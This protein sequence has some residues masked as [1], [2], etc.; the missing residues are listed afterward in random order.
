MGDAA[1]FVAEGALP[2]RAGLSAWSDLLA[3]ARTRRA[4]WIESPARQRED[5]ALAARRATLQATASICKLNPS[6]YRFATHSGKFMTKSRVHC[7]LDRALVVLVIIA[8]AIGCA[9]WDIHEVG[10]EIAAGK[11]VPAGSVAVPPR[12]PMAA[13]ASVAAPATTVFVRL[14]R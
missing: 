2:P 13:S 12:P 1:S 8:G 7:Q 9:L 3:I 4:A 11:L 6:R 5:V 10:S 14:A